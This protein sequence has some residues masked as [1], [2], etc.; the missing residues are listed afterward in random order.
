MTIESSSVESRHSL[1][2]L[3]QLADTLKAEGLGLQ[4][5]HHHKGVS[6][7]AWEIT[8]APDPYSYCTS[9]MELSS[10]LATLLLSVTSNNKT[11]L[12]HQ[13]P[14]KDLLCRFIEKWSFHQDSFLGKRAGL[15][16]IFSG[17]HQE[18]IPWDSTV[19]TVSDITKTTIKSKNH[20]QVTIKPIKLEYK[21]NGNVQNTTALAVYAQIK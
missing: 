10:R 17:A 21:A 9:I 3:C 12:N 2:L 15:I 11:L 16:G 13:D 7:Q 18:S 4:L 20:L 5:F 19:K 8:R 14:L 6:V 1:D